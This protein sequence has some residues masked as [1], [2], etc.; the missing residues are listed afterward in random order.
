MA[1]QQLKPKSN[2][3]CP[4][5]FSP[6]INSMSAPKLNTRIADTRPTSSKVGMTLKTID[7]RAK[8]IDLE[9]RSITL[10]ITPVDRDR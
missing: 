8:L 10:E 2:Y 1:M 9:P 5:D 4:S 6:S 7:V 3:R